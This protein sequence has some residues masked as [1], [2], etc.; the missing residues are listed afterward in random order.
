MIQKDD[1]GYAVSGTNTESLAGFEQASHE[2]RCMIGD[3]LASVDRALAARPD[4]TMAHV[5]RGWLH[6]L[7]TEPDGL[8]VAR[9]CA[10][11][12]AVLPATDR[13]RR[14]VAA[15]RLVADGRWRDAGLALEDLS[16]LYPRDPL[17]LQVGHQ[18]DFFTGHSRMLRDRIARALPAW[19]RD[20]RGYHAVLG[21]YAF[22]LEE[23]G[24]YEQAEHYGRLS[25]EL[26]PRDGWG[27]HAVAHVHEMRNRPEEGIAWLRPN[28]ATWSKE[29]F[30]AVH[31]WWH[32]ALYHLEREEIGEVLQ[33]FDGPIFGARSSLLLELVDASAMLWRLQLRGV[34]V[35]D[36]WH[37]VADNWEPV[38]A[39]GNYAFNDLHAMLAFVG[40]GRRDAQQAVLEAQQRALEQGGDNV[41]FIREVGAAAVRAVQ[42]FGEGDYAR[43]V[44]LLRP[45]RSSAHRFGGSHAQRDLL[46]L[47]LIEAA[48]CG[49]DA[50]LGA[51]L[52]AER[53]AMR[54]RSPLARLFTTRASALGSTPA[55]AAAP[56]ADRVPA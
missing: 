28:A 18:V 26:E 53:T 41:D 49:G 39:A 22:G 52:A 55:R 54:P 46:D 12:A 10:T 50:A 16:A 5:L 17:A 45:I 43:T 33:L 37:A 56:I 13:E 8:P 42:A 2:L 30:L 14:H 11:A 40:A 1:A 23:T 24:D 31:N 7:G 48:L 25:V 32:L 27:W 38:A 29:S 36:R 6:L 15:M 35:G 47:T 51:A 19:S 21:M 44:A 34:D 4:M 9:D 20:M 3:P